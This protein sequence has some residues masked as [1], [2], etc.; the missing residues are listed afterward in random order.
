MPQVM[1]E[2]LLTVAYDGDNLMLSMEVA[3]VMAP[4]LEVQEVWTCLMMIDFWNLH[5]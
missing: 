3:F 5:P 2:V 1:L 4:E